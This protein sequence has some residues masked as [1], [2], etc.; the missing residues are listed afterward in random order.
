MP[1]PPRPWAPVLPVV[2]LIL[3]GLLGLRGAVAAPRWNG[4]LR[5]DSLIVGLALE[6]V[7]GVVLVWMIRR[8][9]R[10]LRAARFGGARPDVVSASSAAF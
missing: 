6:A 4:P 1:G 7:L 9:A 3:V 10:F 2:L 5:P 8:R